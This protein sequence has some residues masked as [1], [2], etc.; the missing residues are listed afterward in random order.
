MK[1]AVVKYLDGKEITADEIKFAK[2]SLS[3]RFP[4]NFETYRQISANISSKIIHNLPDDYFKT[5][6]EKLDSVNLEEVNKIAADSIYPEELITVLVGD[7]KK[8]TELIKEEEF[9]E[10]VIL[11]FDDVL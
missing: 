3:R 10:I 6:L 4:S 1:K 11:S 7:S 9:G 8:I 5:Y 2:S